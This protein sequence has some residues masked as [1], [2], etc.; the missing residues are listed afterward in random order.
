MCNIQSIKETF[1]KNSKSI[2]ILKKKKKKNVSTTFPFL[3]ME[4]NN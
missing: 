2:Y 1:H 3:T 4:Y